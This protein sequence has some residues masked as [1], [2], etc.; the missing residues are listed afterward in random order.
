M[1]PEATFAMAGL[2]LSYAKS[3]NPVAAR[4]VL[5]EMQAMANQTYVSPLYIGLVYGALGVARQGVRMVR[6]S[7]R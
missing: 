5:E 2:G 4:K 3:G 7:L 6:Q 1:N